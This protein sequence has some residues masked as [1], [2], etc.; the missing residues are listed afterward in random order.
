MRWLHGAFKRLIERLSERLLRM[1]LPHSIVVLVTTG[2]GLVALPLAVAVVLAML[3]LDELTS[4]S[5]ALVTRDVQLSRRSE[6]VVEQLND[7]ERNARQYL[8]LEDPA[9]LDLYQDNHGLFNARLEILERLTPAA[10]APDNFVIMRDEAQTVLELLLSRAD[11]SADNSGSMITETLT[12]HLTRLRNL[13]LALVGF[14]NRTV[15]ERLQALLN[16]ANRAEARLFWLSLGLIPIALLGGLAFIVLITHP[17][18]RMRTAI[19]TLG[20]GDLTR[21]VVITGPRELHQVGLELDW[22]RRRLLDLETQK[23]RFLR[24]I[25]HELKTPLASIREG[26]ELLVDGTV[27]TLTPAQTE[28]ADIVRGNSIELQ[29]LIDNLLSF[30][31][32]Q[33][34]RLSPRLRVQRLRPLLSELVSRYRLMLTTKRLTLHLPAT[35]RIVWADRQM[36]LTALDNLLSNA[37]K[38]TPEGGDIRIESFREADSILIDVIDTGP[39]IAPVDRER[40]FEPFFSN[41]TASD[42]RLRGTGIGLSVARECIEAHHGTIEIVDSDRSGAHFRLR[43][44]A[45]PD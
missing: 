41:S 5:Q 16:A 15:D 14:S 21:P 32:W 18:R 20:I 2:F 45:Q 44:P 6:Q 26:V 29:S 35:D 1:P 39:G 33:Q 24:H 9:L 31:A 28:V 30:N 19:Q 25:S 12:E 4:R 7:M 11:A 40:V 17:V 27:G 8:V 38:F 37:I 10:F 42:T 3:Y 34:Q 36:L 43:L 23:N 13:A 22:L